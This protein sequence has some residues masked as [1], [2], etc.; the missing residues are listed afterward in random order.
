MKNKRRKFLGQLSMVSAGLPFL[1]ETL[2]GSPL[3]LSAKSYSRILG[4]NQ[5]I[6]LAFQGLGRRFPGLL[7]SALKLKNVYKNFLQ[8]II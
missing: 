1:S 2:Y 7:R 8:P 3:K 4:S 6:G 5:R